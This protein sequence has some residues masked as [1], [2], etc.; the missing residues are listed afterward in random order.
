MGVVCN[1]VPRCGG[2]ILCELRC[3]VKCGDVECCN[4]RNGAIEMQNV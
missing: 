1:G 4:F 2:V 3:D